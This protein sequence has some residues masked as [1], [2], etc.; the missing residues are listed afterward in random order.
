MPA[1]E[2]IIHSSLQPQIVGV[3]VFDASQ[4]LLPSSCWRPRRN[5]VS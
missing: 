1:F 2:D 5:N 4:A 3:D